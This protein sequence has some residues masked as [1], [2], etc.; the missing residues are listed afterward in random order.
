M[1]QNIT[2][3]W[4]G[5]PKAIR[6]KDN[7]I[8]VTSLHDRRLTAPNI[9]AQLNQ[10]HENSVPTF[11]VRRRL[12]EAGLYD[13]I[14]VKKPLLRKQNNVK[15]LQWAKAHK[16]WI[17]QLWNKVLWTDVSK[18]EIF[19][20]NRRV[21]V[22]RKVGEKAATPNI[23][24][25]IKHGRGSVMVVGAFANC[26]VK[27]KLAITVYCSINP[28]GMLFV[29]QGFVIMQDNDAKHTSKL[30]QR[31]IKRNE[32]EHIIQLM[33]WPAQSADLNPI[34]LVWINLTEKSEWN[35]PLVLLTSGNICRKAGKNYLLSTSSVWW[36]ECWESVK[37]W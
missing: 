28:S 31:Y 27:I 30:C 15:R 12:C 23:T 25:T 8:R 11:T 3:T 5:R 10:C 16:D 1:G 24:P 36:K 9:T 2:K 4:A 7:F 6:V 17:I 22:W 20:S 37:Q 29:G 14:A 19:G 35:T 32:E 18:F 34:E 13:R 26:K 33:P 21:S